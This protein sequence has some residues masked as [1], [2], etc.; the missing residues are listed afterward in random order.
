[1]TKQIVQSELQYS[2][3]MYCVKDVYFSNLKKP[4]KQIILRLEFRKNITKSF[5]V[6]N[7]VLSN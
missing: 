7:H 1:M 6:Y 4:T 3:E 2:I 5:T